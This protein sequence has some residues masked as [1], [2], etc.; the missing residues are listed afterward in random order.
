MGIMS[1]FLILITNRRLR[2]TAV[3]ID[4]KEIH[5]TPIEYK[6]LLL[7]IANK[8][9]FLLIIIYSKRSGGTAKPVI[10]NNQGFY[11]EFEGK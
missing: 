5:L 7:L 1:A 10:Q 9:R 2:K 11:G 4:N 3:L 6:L 8:A